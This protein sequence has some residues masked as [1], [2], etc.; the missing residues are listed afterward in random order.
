MDEGT[1][2]MAT[3]VIHGSKRVHQ[4][5]DQG[6]GPATSVQRTVTHDQ[7]ASMALTLRCS[8]DNLKGCCCENVRRPNAGHTSDLELPSGTFD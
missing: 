4:L 8:F 3:E 1:T 7:A 2:R 6:S 5:D